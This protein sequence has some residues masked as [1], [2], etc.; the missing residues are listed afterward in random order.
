MS[1]RTLIIH[2]AEYPDAAMRWE[3]WEDGAAAMAGDTLEACP[4]PTDDLEAFGIAPAAAVTL[5]RFDLLD[6][7]PNQARVAAALLAAEASAAPSASLHV[8]LGDIDADGQRLMAV[9]DREAMARWLALALAAGHDLRALVPAPLLLPLDVDGF[10]T[11]TINGTSLMRST[12]AA[13]AEDAL[14]PLIVG[15]A[16]VRAIESI[17]LDA[18]AREAPLDL[19]QGRFARRRRG[20][21]KAAA[22]RVALLALS[23]LVLTIATLLVQIVRYELAADAAQARAATAAAA[24]VPRGTGPVGPA[25]A[26]RLTAIEGPGGGLP[27][28]VTPVLVVLERAPAVD[29]TRLDYRA[30]GSLFLEL[31][32]PDA[33]QLSAVANAIQARGVRVT[34]GTSGAVDGRTRAEFTVRQP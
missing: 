31:T 32:A 17:L 19:R 21:D 10:T 23:A 9:V 29:L 24:V 33:A 13:F 34:L 11:A 15:E 3:L 1:A 2:F 7:A 6:L 18:A 27:R 28:L 12:D 26:D 5:H 4:P 25:L 14:T 30:D 8:A 20:I 22:R 16:S